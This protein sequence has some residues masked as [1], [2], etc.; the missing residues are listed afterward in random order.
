M[1]RIDQT[2]ASLAAEITGSTNWLQTFSEGAQD[3]APASPAPAVDAGGAPAV[4]PTPAPAPQAA[5]VL[6]FGGRKVPE[7]P[8]TRALYEDWRNQQA[9]LTKARQ[10]LLTYK[11]TGPVPV[12]QAPQ[13]PATPEPAGQP[14][15]GQAPAGSA[16][17]NLMAQLSP[18]Q[19]QEF[20]AALFGDDPYGAVERFV[21]TPLVQQVQQQMAQ[22]LTPVQQIQQ[23]LQM[24]AERQRMTD[25][26]AAIASKYEDF[27]KHLPT[28]SQM[29]DQRPELGR[30]PGGL[31]FLYHAAKGQTSQA[32]APAPAPAPTPTSPQDLLR[33]PSV[34][35][36][37]LSDPDIRKQIEQEYLR[38]VV[39]GQPAA[40]PVL[41]TQPAA[42]APTAPAEKPKSLKDAHS[43]A[44]AY[45]ATMQNGG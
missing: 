40:P 16:M 42:M 6:D 5:P 12:Q 25:E 27:D 3:P 22:V 2:P 38:T 18:E 17:A 30:L 9:A 31:E 23:H 44:L 20:S 10:E 15:M 13:A 29:L 8:E 4:D 41:G 14:P 24:Q 11:A 21:V 7:T 28:I 39:T 36:Q 43:Q 1:E 37:L 35:Q 26:V 19:R 34:R 32:P 45:L 33:D